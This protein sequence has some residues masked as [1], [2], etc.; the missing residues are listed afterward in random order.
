[1]CLILLAYRA[2]EEYPLIIAS[3]RD[4]YYNRST[5]KAHFWKDNLEILG[6]RDKKY[7][8]TWLGITKTGKIGMLTNYRNPKNHK[9]K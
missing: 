8:G 7:G 4:E 5:E 1:M 9:I 2:N 6:G 3:N